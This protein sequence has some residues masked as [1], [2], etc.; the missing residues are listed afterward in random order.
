VWSFIFEPSGARVNLN[1]AAAGKGS[2][3][4]VQCNGVQSRACGW[5]AEE[6]EEEEARL[7]ELQIV[8]GGQKQRGGC[9]PCVKCYKIL[10]AHV[11]VAST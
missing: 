2:C 11:A 3:L 8:G 4:L 10:F 7:G 9:A 1:L 6:E 5:K